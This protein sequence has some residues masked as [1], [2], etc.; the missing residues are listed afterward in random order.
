[1]FKT[2]AGALL[3]VILS[4]MP[5]R[6]DSGVETAGT[7]I[8]IALPLIAGGITLCKDDWKGA[9]QVTLSTALTVGTALALKQIVREQ[10]PDHSDFHS[11]PS[12][13]SAL[14]FAPAQFLWQRYGWEYGLPAYGAAT[15]VAWSRVDA[16]KHHWWDTAASFGISLVWNEIFTTRYNRYD[17]W[18]ADLDASPSGALATLDYRW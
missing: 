12:D 18:S 8:A 3:A 14:A 7:G 17:S 10:R 16:Q 1:M 4:G 6:A 5:A 2:M 15:F 9:A 13:T 11:F